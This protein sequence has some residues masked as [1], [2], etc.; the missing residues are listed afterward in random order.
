MSTIL[1]LDVGPNSIGWAI[2]YPEDNEIVATGVRIF[3]EGVENYGSFGQQESKNAA[4]RIARGMRRQNQRF[5]MRR[6][7]IVWQLRQ[8]KMYPQNE[9]EVPDYFALN[10]Y[11]LRANGLD[12]KLTLLEFGRALYH[13]NE[14][15]GFKSNRKAGGSEDS[16]IFQSK[17]G[18]IGISDT[19]QA[20]VD[21]NY[22][23]LGEYLKSLDTDEERQRSRYTLRAMYEQ[24]FEMLWQKQKSFY[25]ELL[26]DNAKEKLHQAIFF[27]RKL[28]SQ[29]S[30]VAHC[31]FES[32]KRCAPKSSPTFQYFRILEQLSRLKITDGER[33]G[34]FLIQEER[35]LIASELNKREKMTFK[36]IS[37][38]LGFSENAIFNL[39][40]EKHLIGNRTNV[41]LAKVFGKK[42]WYEKSSK[43]QYDRWNDFHFAVD[44]DWLKNQGKT[45]WCLDT[46]QIEKIEKVSLEKGY[47][48]MSQKAMSKIIPFLENSLTDNGEPMTYDKAVKTAGYHHS[49]IHD[50][51]GMLDKLPLPDNIRNP[52]VQQALF[53]MRKLVNAIVDEYGNPDT[54]KVEL[55]RDLKLP[56]KR[57]EQ[58]STENKKRQDNHDRIRGI[59][60]DV[61]IVDISMDYIVRY[62]LWEECD[63]VCP[64]SGKKINSVSKLFSA[65]YEVEHIL[66]YSRSLDNSFM[67]KTLSHI[68]WN[69]EKGNKTP[70]ETWGETVKYD[71]ILERSK[72][73]PYP[74]Y[75]RFL[76]KELKQDEF[77]NRQ[78]TDT[79]YIAKEVR[80]YL[81]YICTDVRT[82]PGTATARLRKYWGLNEILSKD[83]DIK[84]REDHRH[85]AV[86]AL[87]VANTERKYIQHLSTFHHYKKTPE[88]GHFPFPWNTFIL[89][90]KKAINQI[91]VS[92]KV[93]NKLS[94]ALHKESMYGLIKDNDGKPKLNANNQVLYGMKKPVH[95]LKDSEIKKIADEKVKLCVKEWSA[96]P[97]DNR[98]EYPSLPS[99]QKIKRVRIH[100]VHT[101]VIELRPGVFVEPGSNHHI[102]I[103]ENIKTGKRTGKVVS[104]FEAIQRQKNGLPVIDKKADDGWKYI[105]SLSINEMVLI[106]DKID[107]INWN[108]KALLS[109]NLYRVQIAPASLQISFRHHT[110]AKLVTENNEKP[111][112]ILKKPNTFKGIKVGINNLG[113]I[114]RI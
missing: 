94:G 75:K 66:P 49:E 21:G 36:Q 32:K 95:N 56:R 87:V 52:I 107:E 54:I 114:F 103:F 27:Q 33:R 15:R 35:D 79:A 82:V 58:I 29:K 74:K 71:Q 28:K 38:K 62:K 101:N 4:R 40:H 102:A 34:D 110:V 1:G 24:E 16:K 17:D 8:L 18:L 69:K 39:E 42:E 44:M 72:K 2:I 41:Q 112:L 83:V 23:T 63:K 77:I 50:H 45:K 78:L 109:K 98:P 19:E 6:N 53:E 37:K 51:A 99:G 48:R 31:I 86:D 96:L 30:T 85:H 9:N 43:E 88:K 10:P 55:V 60:K 106:S 70:F 57:R 91:L 104:L 59:L 64:Y 22:R 13:I 68:D 5:K 47:G 93:R 12:T 26:T 76:Q 100:D 7:N 11:E 73:L 61:G 20:M 84:N 111:G 92:H 65:E 3:P 113:N 81:S 67:N 108:D 80:K 90:A 97:R 105:M 89:D 46:D 25:R 14:R